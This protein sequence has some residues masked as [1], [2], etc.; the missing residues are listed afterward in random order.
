MPKI[1]IDTNVLLDTPE[2]I[3]AYDEVVI[4]FVVLEELDKLKTRPET[5]YKA[6]KAVRFIKKNL[7]KI[8]LVG[9]VT[10]DTNDNQI[11]LAAK[12]NG[13]KLLTN[14]IILRLK[15]IAEGVELEE[16]L[17]IEDYKGYSVIELDDETMCKFYSGLEIE[18]FDNVNLNEYVMLTDGFDVIDKYKMTRDGL[19][20]LKYKKIMNKYVGTVKPRNDQQELYMDL[21][22]DQDIKVKVCTGNYGTGKDYLALSAFLGLLDEGKYE[23][24]LWV[25]NNVEAKGTEPVG[26]LPGSLNDKLIVYADIVSDFVGGRDEFMGMIETGKIELVHPGFLR[27]RDLRNSIIYCTEAQN[28]DTGL[29]KLVLSRVSEGS[30]IFFNGDIKQADKAVFKEDSGLFHLI[31]RLKDNAN[32]G[33][34]HLEKTERSEI[35]GLAELL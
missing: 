1:V 25:R 12:D 11:L 8:E 28:M 17:G 27:G 2:I 10:L 30:M 4:P 34:V 21:L 35:A 6:R 16:E 33:Y 20:K 3:L 29:I 24:I 9:E 23:K 14:D 5:G 26:F 31:S 15:A 18:A 13:A 32:F 22:Q 19:K 7:D